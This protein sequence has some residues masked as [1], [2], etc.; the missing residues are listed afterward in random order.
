MESGA[1][2]LGLLLR[3]MGTGRV[4]SGVAWR[5]HVQ[6]CG[7]ASQAIVLHASSHHVLSTHTPAPT[8]GADW[9]SFCAEP[10]DTEGRLGT[11]Q[12][13]RHML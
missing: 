11:A 9:M 3:R 4:S 2:A 7:R 6:T 13:E 10:P 1:E 5:Q 12:N 8:G